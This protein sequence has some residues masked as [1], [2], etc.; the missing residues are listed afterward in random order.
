MINCLLFLLFVFCCGVGG[1]GIM[2]YACYGVVVWGLC[3]LLV[4]VWSHCT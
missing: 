4:N 1:L 2:L 3:C